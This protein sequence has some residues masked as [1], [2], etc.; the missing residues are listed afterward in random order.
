MSFKVNDAMLENLMVF[1]ASEGITQ[2]GGVRAGLALLFSKRSR[3]NNTDN[4]VKSANSF[5]EW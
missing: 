2:S 3:N 1:C 4:T 5:D